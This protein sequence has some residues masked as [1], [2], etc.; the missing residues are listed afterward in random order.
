MPKLDPDSGEHDILIASA[1]LSVALGSCHSTT[2]VDCPG[3]I[4]LDWLVGQEFITGFSSSVKN[5]GKRFKNLNSD[6]S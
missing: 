4:S 1:E 5:A 6:G 2:A 3:P